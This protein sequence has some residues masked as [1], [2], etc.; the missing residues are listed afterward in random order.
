MDLSTLSMAN[1]NSITGK[2]DRLKSNV[3]DADK[4]AMREKAEEFESIFLSQMLAP[5]METVETDSMFGGGNSEK[6]YKSM[7]VQEFG[8]SI[9]QSGG[10][11][12]ADK[13]YSELL[14]LQEG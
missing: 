9:T 3:S 14:K 6:I 1:Q 4:Q 8:K 11:G 10:I 2:L 12:I 13:V 7:M 5:M